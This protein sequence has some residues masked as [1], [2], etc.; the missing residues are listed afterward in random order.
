[1]DQSRL[2]I[3][4]IA[5]ILTHNEIRCQSQQ[6]MWAASTVSVINNRDARQLASMS[7]TQIIESLC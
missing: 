5:V 6:R 4:P 1:M 2:K 7:Q 3:L